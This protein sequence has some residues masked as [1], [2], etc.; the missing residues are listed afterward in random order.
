MHNYTRGP[1]T[2][3]DI[4]ICHSWNDIK[5]PHSLHLRVSMSGLG[6]DIKSMFVNGW[7]ATH[8]CGNNDFCSFLTSF[9]LFIETATAV[10]TDHVDV[11]HLAKLLSFMIDLQ[12]DIHIGARHG[13]I[14]SRGLSHLCQKFFSKCSKKTAMLTCKITLPT[15]PK[16]Q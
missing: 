16:T 7:N 4:R 8:R 14:F 5:P 12:T 10:R 15:Y 3:A 2:G 1:W 9:T 6:V 13:T 11:V